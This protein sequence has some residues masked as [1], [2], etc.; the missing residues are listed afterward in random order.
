MT[1]Q[2]VRRRGWAL[3]AAIEGLC[4]G[5]GAAVPAQAI[6][7]Q[8]GADAEADQARAEAARKAGAAHPSLMRIQFL[9]GVQGQAPIHASGVYLGA[10]EDG[11]TGYILTAGHIFNFDPAGAKEP[12]FLEAAGHP[13]P[14]APKG[15]GIPL[16]RILVHPGYRPLKDLLAGAAGPVVNDIAV[17]TFPVG[18][19]AAGLMAAAGLRPARLAGAT[20]HRGAASLEAEVAGFGLTGTSASDLEPVDTVRGGPTLVHA[21]RF[22]AGEILVNLA[23]A[24]FTLEETGKAAQ[25]GASLLHCFKPAPE[26]IRAFWEGDEVNT[27]WIQTHAQHVLPA[28]GDSGGPLFME[29]KEGPRVLGI[30]S[31]VTHLSL[32]PEGAEEPMDCLGSLF[33]PVGEHLDWIEAVR[34]GGKA[35]AWVLEPKDRQW[36]LQEAGEGG[37][38]CCSGSCAIL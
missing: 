1:K 36:R 15:S 6:V 20:D 7:V 12:A 14:V 29:T 32:R 31:L 5:L 28:P 30:T 16:G 21:V 38:S 2:A 9:S 27:H 33:V 25:A 22:L 26:P 11:K 13:G 18:K 24:V 10:S 17:I 23:P 4:L 34:T 35:K 19:D 8:A 3:A 37:T